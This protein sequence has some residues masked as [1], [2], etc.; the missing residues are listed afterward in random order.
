MF[1]IN[2]QEICCCHCGWGD[3]CLWIAK[4]IWLAVPYKNAWN[5]PA[6]ELSKITECL[7]QFGLW[8]DECGICHWEFESG[9]IDTQIVWYKSEWTYFSKFIKISLHLFVRLRITESGC[10][11]RAVLFQNINL[12]TCIKYCEC[13]QAYICAHHYNCAICAYLIT[14]LNTSDSSSGI[15]L[16]WIL[17]FQKCSV[18]LV[19]LIRMA[20]D[21]VLCYD[22]CW[23]RLKLIIN[24]QI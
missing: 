22:C 10:R 18:V 9:H 14:Q 11:H 6:E 16:W 1:Y 24:L 13:C 15:I 21:N 5:R 12:H 17:Y 20:T 23:I 4:K 19:W 7:G 8:R 3:W 2:A